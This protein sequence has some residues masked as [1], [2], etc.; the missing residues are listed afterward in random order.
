[1]NI[2]V[3][4]ASRPEQRADEEIHLLLG[5]K[6]LTTSGL[7]RCLV[8]TPHPRVNFLKEMEIEPKRIS[9]HAL[10]FLKAA[11]RC[12]EQRKTSDGKSEWLM[13]PGNV[14]L[15]FSIELN[16]KVL[17]Y[18]EN[19]NPTETHNIE[20]LF[21]QLNGKTQ[22][23]IINDLGIGKSEFLN[24]LNQVANAFEFWRYVYEN[25]NSSFSFNLLFLKQLALQLIN[26]TNKIKV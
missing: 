15:A 14:C 12:S 18:Q 19:H 16:L 8:G 20:K 17:I 24:A 7:N 4:D 3:P 1:M 6:R 10:S 26:K 5:A 21:K 2:V 9:S 13:I 25:Q 23:K 11:E 22:N